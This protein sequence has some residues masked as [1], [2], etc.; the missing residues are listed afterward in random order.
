MI[1]TPWAARIRTSTPLTFGPLKVG[2]DVPLLASDVEQALGGA[3][4]PGHHPGQRTD[5]QRD[6]DHWHGE[7]KVEVPQQAVERLHHSGGK[8]D[9]TCGEHP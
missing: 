9:L 1:T 5:G 8:A 2:R 6:R 4:Q 3:V 7:R